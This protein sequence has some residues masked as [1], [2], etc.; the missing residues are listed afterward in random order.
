MSAVAAEHA[1]RGRAAPERAAAIG[2]AQALEH[3]G[4]ARAW[5]GPDPYDGLNATRLA[6]ARRGSPLPMRILTQ[7]VKRSPLDLRPLLGIP[8]GLSAA[9]LALAT[10]AYARNGFLDPDDA[11]GKLRRTVAELQN[12]RCTTFNEP[13]W[14]YHFDVQTRVFFYPRTEPNTIATA[15]AGLGLL[16]AHE[17]AGEQGALELALG[18]GEF[19]AR[20]V[21][22]TQTTQGAYFGYLPGDTTPIH[23][24]NMLVCALLARLSRSIAREDLARAAV[25]GVEYTTSRQRPDGSWPYGEQPHLDWVDGFHTGYV[26]DC[27]LTCIEAGIGG[28]A[29]EEAWRRGLRFYVDALIE[30]D[31]TPRYMPDSRYPIDGQCVAQAIHTLSRASALEPGLAEQR[32]QVLRFA[33][34]RFARSDGAFAFQR[35]RLWLN[36]TAHPRWVQAPMLVALTQLIASA[37]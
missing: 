14:G 18:A 33:L 21:P 8:D 37:P 9:T 16:D 4:H 1:P 34:D 15:F 11:R 30:R 25:A 7:A 20:Q 3:W 24:A 19:F 6:W 17:L 27:L 35:E 28:P 32:W 23:N 31:G 12:L 26:L 5:R 36:R 13:C 22:Q 10:S 29:A 2:A